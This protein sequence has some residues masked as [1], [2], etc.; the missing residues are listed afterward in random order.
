MSER[1]YTA[2]SASWPDPHREGLQRDVFS[3][4]R[5]YGAGG[6]AYTVFG[7]GESKGGLY[8]RKD[9]TWGVGT[10]L[11]VHK[12]SIP[13]LLRVLSAILEDEDDEEGVS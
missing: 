12:A 9:W 4:E 3:V 2:E 6:G 13:A 10:N 1:L 8:A 5:D 7:A 11:R